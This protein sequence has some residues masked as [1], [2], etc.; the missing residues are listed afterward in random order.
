[1][2]GQFLVSAVA[3]LSITTSLT[4][5]GLKKL[6]KD[7]K[8]SANF[9]A[10][11]TS[12]VLTLAM[13]VSVIIYKDIKITPQVIITIP[14]LMFLSSMSSMVGFDKVKQLIEQIARV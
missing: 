12:I 6:L 13:S 1:M 10:V 2:N 7:K 3:I 14:A 9:L 4:V 11:I 8:Y 5:E